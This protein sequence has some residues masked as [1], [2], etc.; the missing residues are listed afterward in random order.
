MTQRRRLELLRTNE[1]IASAL[2]ML[3]NLS[4][5]EEENLLSPL[6]GTTASL[7][8]WLRRELP[9]GNFITKGIDHTADRHGSGSGTIQVQIWLLYRK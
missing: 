7:E 8:P 3:P 5:D 4:E 6:E 2:E 9:T 1:E